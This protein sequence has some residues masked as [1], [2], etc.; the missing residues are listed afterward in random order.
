MTTNEILQQLQHLP[1]HTDFAPYEA[2]LLAAAEQRESIV[3]ELIAAIDR[4]T[5]DPAT[6]QAE[7]GLCLHNFA[8]Y[9][10]AQFREPQ[11]LNAF[12]RFL[13][14]PG[15]LPLDLT[16]DMITEDG[17]TLLASVCGGDSAPLLRLALNEGVNPF[18]REQAIHGLLVQEVWGE[19]PREALLA[20]LRSLFAQLA[21]PGDS[22]VW[23]G[24]VGAVCDLNL[25]ELLPEVRQAYA[26]AIVD[27]DVV[28]SLRDVEGELGAAAPRVWDTRT[29]EQRVRA[30]TE[31][32]GPIDAVA[33]CSIWLCFRD[34]DEE[35]AGWSTEEPRD[36]QP[37]F[38]PPPVRPLP[39]PVP[40]RAPYAVGRNDPCPC[41]SGKKFK[42]CCG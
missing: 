27:E 40:F 5:N 8:L 7:R 2:A 14:L 17:A 22:Y 18:V 35:S 30:F 29:G 6:Y 12:V 4:V 42:K 13:S 11:A 20:D 3:P 28:G 16:G 19:R 36:D 21:R 34:D 1:D 33:G 38:S 25:C 23:A 10:L 26:A 15:D 32:H 39:D 41:G 31:R 24:L 37:G 9:L